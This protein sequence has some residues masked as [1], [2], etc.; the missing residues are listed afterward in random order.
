MLKNF[1]NSNNLEELNKYYK[2]IIYEFERDY[3]NIYSYYNN[4]DYGENIGFQIETNFS[5][6]FYSIPNKINTLISYDKFYNSF[7]DV[8]IKNHSIKDKIKLKSYFNLLKENYKLCDELINIFKYNMYYDKKL[9]IFIINN[10]EKIKSLKK[11][12]KQKLIKEEYNKI[13]KK[14]IQYKKIVE[15]YMNN[16]NNYYIINN[17]NKQFNTIEQINLTLNNLIKKIHF[18]HI[19]DNLTSYNNNEQYSDLFYNV[20]NILNEKCK[21]YNIEDYNYNYSECYKYEKRKKD[22]Y[23]EY[24]VYKNKKQK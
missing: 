18:E 5:T 7:L 15:D 1:I 22:E 10:K 19:C 13:N 17:L 2:G 6:N 3:D 14:Y 9:L 16:L 24:N 20:V 23:D 12:D 4:P 8:Y 21:D 11:E